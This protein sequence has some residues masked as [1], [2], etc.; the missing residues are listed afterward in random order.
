MFRFTPLLLALFLLPSMLFAQNKLSGKI[1]D[2]NNKETLPGAYIFLKNE[3]GDTLNN[4]VSD[5][6][7]NFEINKPAQNSFLLEVSFIGYET[8]SKQINNLSGSSLGTIE[9]EED[10]ELLETYEIEG[11]ALS[12]EVRGD[13]V[14]FNSGAFKTRPQAE[15]NDLIRKMPGVVMQTDGTIE[16]QGET[17][18]KVLVDGEPFFGDDPAMA[19]QNIPVAI[20]DK[21]EF[22]DQKSDQAILTGFDDGETIKTINIITKKESRGGKFGKFFGGYGTD[23]NY[24]LGGN[25][26]F[27]N[28]SRRLTVLGLSN[29]INQQNFSADDLSGAFGEGGGSRRG[30][31]GRNNSLTTWES[32]GITTTNSVGV[33]FSDKFDDGKAKFTGSY[34]FND[35]KNF[36]NHNSSREYILPSDSLQ[37]YDEVRNDEN[38]RQRHRL[39]MRLDYDIN[40]KHALIWRPNISYYRQES[41]DLLVA[42]NLFDTN[43][44]ISESTNRTQSSYESIRLNNH[45][46]YRYKF[47]KE[48]R[49]IS[50][51]ISTQ[52]NNSESESN[53]TSENRNFQNNNLD[54]LVQ[55]ST[56]NSN[57]FEYEFEIEY[58][59]PIGQYS[60]MRLE[61]EVGNDIGKNL[62]EVYQ[63]EM[64]TTNFELDSTLSN[65]FENSY[66]QH[67]IGLGYRFNNEKLRIFSSLDYELSRLNSDRLFPGYENTKRNFG[68]FVPR[69]IFDYE[70]DEETNLR[71][72]YRTD[73]DAP[74]VRQLQ[75]VIDNDNPLQISTGNP[76][77]NQE[78]EHRMYTRFRKMDPETSKSFFMYLSA[79]KRKNYLGNSTFI[80][81]QDTLIQG[82]VLLRQGGQF[83]RPVNLDNYWNARSYFA[84][85]FPLGFMQSNLNLNTRASISNRP[86]LINGQLNNN[87][88]IGIGQGIG[89]SSNVSEDLDFNI[90]TRGNYNIVRSSLQESLNNNYYSQNTR[91]DFYWNFTPNFF[92]SSNVNHTLYQGLGEGFDQSFWLMN[93]DVGYRF[94]DNQNGELK[95]TV[96]DLL[97]QNT[98]I[99]RNV[100][101]VYIEDERTQVL[102]Q[103]F[104]LT[105]TYNLRAFGNMDDSM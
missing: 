48:G 55:N 25:I 30:G 94:L 62:Q 56:N 72:V 6:N 28:G 89:L 65:Q 83:S 39:D 11:S 15:A 14:A 74:R 42:Q 70:F 17:V 8:F 52:L 54:S 90:S 47:D 81:S 7:G 98:S 57:E 46:T 32:P 40:E 10:V 38:H 41:Q 1:V 33:N 78:Y 44:P 26:N 68:N 60:Q 93:L 80:A 5:E 76:N 92:I 4:A 87:K 49:T 77:L 2:K 102:Q 104:M 103:F 50:T 35:S 12:G 95:L 58:T 53:L 18:G 20:I 27:F 91:I 24:L 82:D 73:T 45:L 19:M 101:D 37:L 34:F 71:L 99:E 97:D 43:T 75:E 84:F 23:D 29:N 13:T 61:Y 86:G 59:E 16:V 63:R 85:G 100:T 69:I 9:I 64:E 96:F 21:I 51:S 3:Q 36:L 105:F 66:M 22:L 31:G 79:A 88:N 67:E